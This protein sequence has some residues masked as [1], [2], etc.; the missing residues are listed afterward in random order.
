MANE[1]EN[2]NRAMSLLREA[3]AVL[4]QNTSIGLHETAAT[5]TT[6][7]VDTGRNV[8]Q[9]TQSFSAATALPST[10]TLG[11]VEVTPAAASSSTTEALRNF[12]TLF[13]P[14][15]TTS[16]QS[17]DTAPSHRQPVAKRARR[18]RENNSR[19]RTRPET[20]THDVFCLANIDEEAT[21][22]RERKEQLQRACLGRSK[23]KFNANSS[24]IELEEKL[25]EVFPRLVN[26]RGFEL[27]RRGSSGNCLIVIHKPGSGYTVKYLRES[28][29]LGQALLYV[30]PL[31]TNLDASPEESSVDFHSEVRNFNSRH[32]WLMIVFQLALN[33][34][35]WLLLG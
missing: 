4:A 32:S 1:A 15:N 16:R 35:Y 8:G 18:G 3:A 6:P 13:A 29:S 27:L 17:R 31:Q 14:Y 22:S 24:A 7:T 34:I 23:V 11:S 12:R 9:S 20:W 2:V 19:G 21:P 33:M 10:S 5:D 26:G 28:A 30:R 25:E